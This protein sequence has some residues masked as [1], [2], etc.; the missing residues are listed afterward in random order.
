MSGPQRREFGTCAH[1]WG[2]SGFPST[3]VPSASSWATRWFWKKASSVSSARGGARP[4]VLTRKPSP[5]C[6]A[7]RGRISPGPL[8]GGRCGSCAPAWLLWPR[9]GWHYCSTMSCLVITTPTSLFLSA[10]WCIPS[11]HGWASTWPRWLLM[12]F[13]CLQV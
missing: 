10:N 2:V 3:Q 6:C 5:S 8:Q 11:W 7:Y 9:Y 13:I 1:G 12:P 4:T